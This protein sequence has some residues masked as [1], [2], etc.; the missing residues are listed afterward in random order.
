MRM[1]ANVPSGSGEKL[2]QPTSRRHI[3]EKNTPVF[4]EFLVICNQTLLI[5]QYKTEGYTQKVEPWATVA[6]KIEKSL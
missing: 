2:S 6:I 1:K 5:E 4:V 3:I